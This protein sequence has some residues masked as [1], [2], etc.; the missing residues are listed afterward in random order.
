MSHVVLAERTPD[1]SAVAAIREVLSV[2]AVAFPATVSRLSESA[3]PDAGVDSGDNDS[4]RLRGELADSRAEAARLRAELAAHAAADG[5]L[6]EVG[7]P[8]WAATIPF[9]RALAAA[10]TDADRRALAEDRRAVLERLRVV[11]PPAGFAGGGFPGNPG[12]G[13]FSRTRAAATGPDA[14]ALLTRAV[15]GG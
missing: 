7:L 3:T 5:V 15:R 1:G 12:G 2:D 4:S 6:A 14:A 13:P 11:H 8:D 9:R 10:P